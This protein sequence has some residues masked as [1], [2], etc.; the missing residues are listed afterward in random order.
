MSSATAA[1]SIKQPEDGLKRF[2]MDEGW[3]IYTLASWLTLENEDNGHCMF[4]ELPWVPSEETDKH[5]NLQSGEE[6]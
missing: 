2:G 6:I 3:W 4:V 1:E 5:D